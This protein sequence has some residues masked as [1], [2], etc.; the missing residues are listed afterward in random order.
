MAIKPKKSTILASYSLD[1]LFDLVKEKTH[2]AAEEK[3]CEVQVHGPRSSVSDAEDCTGNR[4]SKDRGKSGADAAYNQFLAV[5][6][7]EPDDIGKYR[8]HPGADL[9]AWPLFSGRAA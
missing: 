6:V 1:E 7:P 5:F 2:M 3:T 4:C 9:S 8:G